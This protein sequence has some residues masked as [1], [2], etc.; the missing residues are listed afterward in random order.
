MYIDAHWEELYPSYWQFVATISIGCLT[1]ILM[2]WLLISTIYK[3]W[4]GTKQQQGQINN[5]R[6][7]NSDD[8]TA[9]PEMKLAFKILT[10]V[11]LF[12]LWIFAVGGTT[13]RIYQ[14]MFNNGNLACWINDIWFVFAAFARVTVHVTFLVR[15]V[16]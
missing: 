14:T 11:F 9:G 10:I 8:S 16:T 12:C 2:T 3:F 7:N 13:T 5:D 1:C 4:T 6:Q 15:F